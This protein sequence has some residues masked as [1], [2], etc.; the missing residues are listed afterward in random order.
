MVLVAASNVSTDMI[1]RLPPIESKVCSEKDLVCTHSFR[2][3]EKLFF[4]L[5]FFSLM[6][7]QSVDQTTLVL[8]KRKETK[9]RLDYTA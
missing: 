7:Q 6:S 1:D 2:D 9:C 5:L 8:Q 4:F 3:T